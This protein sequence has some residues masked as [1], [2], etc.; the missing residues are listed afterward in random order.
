MK[1]KIPLLNFDF[2][3]LP[4]YLSELEYGINPTRIEALDLLHPSQFLLYHVNILDVYNM[5][6]GRFPYFFGFRILYPEM[7][8]SFLHWHSM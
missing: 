5:F 4:P 2:F 1:E 8:F 7:Q 3:I 6:D